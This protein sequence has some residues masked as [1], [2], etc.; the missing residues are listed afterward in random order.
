[1]A[2]FDEPESAVRYPAEMT[3]AI[4]IYPGFESPLSSA[5]HSRPSSY[6][7]AGSQRLSPIGSDKSSMSGSQKSEKS[8]RYEKLTIWTLSALQTK[9]ST[10][11]NSVDPDEMAQNEPSHLDLHSL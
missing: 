5:S 10:F 11:T 7:S 6:K 2:V 1:M 8:K 9:A 4:E 3:E